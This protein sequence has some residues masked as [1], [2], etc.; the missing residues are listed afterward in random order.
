MSK[1]TRPAATTLQATELDLATLVP[2]RRNANK[3]TAKGRGLLAASIS[4]LGAGRSV[5]VDAKGQIVAG[6]KS[7]QA[8]VEAGM[9]DAIVIDSDG[10][11]PI[12]VRRTDWDL[13]DRQ[14]PARRYAYADNRVGELDLSW[15]VDILMEDQ[16]LVE[17]GFVPDLSENL[18]KPPPANEE[19]GMDSLDTKHTC[20][21]C[22]FEF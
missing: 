5:V 15:D 4:D 6:N 13:D 7:V 16:D 8:F 18:V 11:R 9:A 22:K 1:K 14:G 19:I 10:T 21:K 20:P 17:S 12:V 2:D 3:G